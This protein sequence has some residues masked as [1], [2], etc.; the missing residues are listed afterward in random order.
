MLCQLILSEYFGVI[1]GVI[2]PEKD[3]T[4]T[5]NFSQRLRLLTPQIFWGAI[6]GVVITGEDFQ[7]NPRIS[8]GMHDRTVLM[9]FISR[10]CRTGS[11]TTRSTGCR[12]E[13][14]PHTTT[15]PKFRKL[16]KAVAV[17]NSL[18]E[19]FS[20]KFRRCWK[21]FPD[22]PAA[23]NAIPAKVWALSG[24]EMAAEKSAPPSGTL[25]DF[26]LRDRHSLLEFF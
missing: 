14:P 18:L 3:K 5:C 19:R 26:L 25:L 11:P 22:F 13:Q 17:R 20:G 10:R 6:S 7:C 8:N 4:R 15:S 1:G 16:E 21:S 24:N 12:A 23:Q 2:V 9:V